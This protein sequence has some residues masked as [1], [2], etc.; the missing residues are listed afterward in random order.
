MH[1]QPKESGLEDSVLE[2][3]DRVAKRPKLDSSVDTTRVFQRGSV[4]GRE[5]KLVETLFGVISRSEAV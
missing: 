2:D 5:S 3:L 1:G 4:A